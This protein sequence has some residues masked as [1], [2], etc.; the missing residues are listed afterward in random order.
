MVDDG[1]T[2][3][4]C[5]LAANLPCRYIRQENAG[6]AK[7]RLTGFTHS[8]GQFIIFLDADDMLDPN[9][10]RVIL[11]AMKNSPNMEVI[12]GALCFRSRSGRLK[13]RRNPMKEID[14]Q[15]LL[16][17]GYA[18]S[19]PGAIVYRREAIERILSLQEA[20]V[21][22]ICNEDYEWLVRAALVAQISSSDLRVLFYDPVGGKSLRANPRMGAQLVRATYAKRLGLSIPKHGRYL[23]LRGQLAR[24]AMSYGV[25]TTTLRRYCSFV[26]WPCLIRAWL[27]GDS[28]GDCL[29]LVNRA[30]PVGS[31]PFQA[32]GIGFGCAPVGGRRRHI[33]P[34][35]CLRDHRPSAIDCPRPAWRSVVRGVSNRVGER[36]TCSRVRD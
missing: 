32:A 12:V 16:A 21:H 6:V 25:A 34:W 23:L 22:P 20:W 14:T 3:N 33:R 17:A 8:N 13:E 7:A 26:S 28:W 2:D 31:G 36:G 24:R 19:P 18:P 15:T 5:V 30:G 10:V 1:S 11:E 29:P 9:G 27:F 4:T 35:P